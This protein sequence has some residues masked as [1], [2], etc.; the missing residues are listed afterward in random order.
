MVCHVQYS[1]VAFLLTVFFANS[2]PAIESQR[3]P[4]GGFWMLLGGLLD[5]TVASKYE[6]TIANSKYTFA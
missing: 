4:S 5:N 6:K 1:T 2:F 3:F